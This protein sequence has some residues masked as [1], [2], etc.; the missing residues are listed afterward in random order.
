MSI[1]CNPGDM[2][3]PS[4]LTISGFVMTVLV[5]FMTHIFANLSEN[6]QN[7]IGDDILYCTITGYFV[8]ALLF[9]TIVGIL[10]FIFKQEHFGAFLVTVVLIVVPIYWLV[11]FIIQLEK[12]KNKIIIDRI[13]RIMQPDLNKDESVATI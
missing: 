1:S 11:N 5:F 7:K 3:Y 10:C 13:A 8:N 6:R 9:V 2:D 4:W 12:T